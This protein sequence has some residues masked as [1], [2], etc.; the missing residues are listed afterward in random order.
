MIDAAT[1]KNAADDGSPGTSSSN[2]VGGSGARRARVRPSTVDRRA[3]R[4]RASARCG[5]GSAP[6]STISVVAVGLQPGEHE[7]RL[8]LRRSRPRARAARRASVAAAD[9]RAA[10]ARRRRGR[11]PWRPSPAA[12]RRR[13]R[14]GRCAQRLVAGEHREERPAGEQPGEHAHRRARVAAVEH[15]VRLRAARRPR[16]RARRS[17]RRAPCGSRTPSCVER[18]RASRRRRRRSRGRVIVLRPSAIAANSSARCEIPLSPGSRSRP[19]SGRPP[20]N[21]SSSGSTDAL[22]PAPCG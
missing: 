9:R 21:A 14:I 5:R 2:G 22:T 15:V 13:A 6:A 20:P 4:A 19:R 16:R 1:T 12:A 3:E 8:H 7:R 18:A 10:R 11:R 17:P